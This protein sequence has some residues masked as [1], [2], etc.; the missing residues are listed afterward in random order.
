MLNGKRI[1]IV[2]PAYNAARTLEQTV[3]DIPME[4][5][6]GV[7]LVDDA[8][9]DSTA[10]VAAT[11]GLTVFR[12]EENFGYGR[13]QKTCY[14]EAL[15][16]GADIIVMVHPDY[17]YSPKL[18]VPIAGMIACG[19]YDAVLA[20]RILGRGAVS[21]G[22]PRYKYV[23]N[24]FLT[25]VQNFLI[26]QKLSEYHSGFRA[27]S[28]Q[29]LESLPLEE[30]SDDFVFDNEMLAQTLFFGY[31]VGEIS[32]PT[33]YFAEASSI[34]FSRSV[35]YGL[36]VLATSARYRLQKMGLYR[37]AIFTQSDSRLS[38]GYYSAVDAE[39]APGKLPG[40]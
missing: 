21:G 13:N 30:N 35:K 22:M 17:Q 40:K 2:M 14:R 19:E 20:S 33:R 5:V 6:D 27:F 37:S 12:H 8:S 29:V 26:G 25:L 1:F 18:I 34:N 39:P 11:M 31:R 38:P 4:V 24:R 23:A 15:K 36:G 32:C 28:R 3:R 9:S 16:T 10:Q 7:L